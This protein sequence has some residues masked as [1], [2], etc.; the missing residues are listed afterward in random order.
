LALFVL[1]WGG[2]WGL[3]LS[4]IPHYSQVVRISISILN[5]Y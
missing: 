2:G 3:F 5:L 1:S 4:D